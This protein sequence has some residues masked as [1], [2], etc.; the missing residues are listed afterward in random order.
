MDLFGRK[1]RA[2][3]SVVKAMF[4]E[5]GQLL[6]GAVTLLGER[7]ATIRVMAGTITTLQENVIAL[8]PPKLK[9]MSSY[10][11]YMSED[12]EDLKWQ[13]D[14]NMIDISTYQ[15]MLKDLEFENAEVSLAVEDLP[16]SFH[17]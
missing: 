4:V 1:T 16:E 13:L 2:E 10:P 5:Q 8:T 11:L 12:E 7:D 3:L 15:Q 14:N 17:Y 6:N 9:T